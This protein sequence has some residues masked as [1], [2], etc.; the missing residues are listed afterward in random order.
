MARNNK[1][2]LNKR[3]LIGRNSVGLHALDDSAETYLKLA[4][5][6]SVK[7]VSGFPGANILDGSISPTA[8]SNQSDLITS[9]GGL[10]S[11]GVL[12]SAINTRTSNM[13]WE[14]GIDDTAIG[15]PIQTLPVDGTTNPASSIPSPINENFHLEYPLSIGRS[16]YLFGD[17]DVSSTYENYP[18]TSP[19]SAPADFTPVTTSHSNSYKTF[20]PV[21]MG[22]NGFYG[23]TTMPQEPNGWNSTNPGTDAGLFRYIFGG[24]DPAG[25]QQLANVPSYGGQQNPQYSGSITSMHPAMGSPPEKPGDPS[26]PSYPAVSSHMLYA[27]PTAEPSGT[28]A[29]LAAYTTHDAS[30]F[31]TPGARTYNE[32]VFIQGIKEP[33]TTP[34]PTLYTTIPGSA[35]GFRVNLK[36]QSVTTRETLDILGG[37]HGDIGD[38]VQEFRVWE[39]VPVPLASQSLPDV[40][41]TII[42]VAKID[43]MSE[44]DINTTVGGVFDGWAYMNNLHA[45]AIQGTDDES[46]VGRPNDFLRVG[47]TAQE[48]V[49]PDPT[50]PAPQEDNSR[51]ER[52]IGGV[53][54]D[55]TE[56]SYTDVLNQMIIH[57]GFEVGMP[58]EHKI[59]MPT[60]PSDYRYEAPLN[61]WRHNNALRFDF[62]TKSDNPGYTPVVS[63]SSRLSPRVHFRYMYHS[64]EAGGV[65]G[66]IAGG[67]GAGGGDMLTEGRNHGPG[68]RQTFNFANNVSRIIGEWN[69][70]AGATT[71]IGRVESDVASATIAQNIGMKG[72]SSP[73]V[74]YFHGYTTGSLAEPT[75]PRPADNH[76]FERTG[77]AV[78]RE[79]W[80]RYTEKFPFQAVA[81][82]VIAGN[83]L[84]YWRRGGMSSYST[85][86][87]YLSGGYIRTPDS[88]T[89]PSN[90]SGPV[91]N[92]RQRG[93]RQKM[94]H[95]TETWSAVPGNMTNYGHFGNAISGTDQVS[96]NFPGTQH[97]LDFGD[98]GRVANSPGTRERFPFATETLIND[99]LVSQKVLARASL[100][101]PTKGFLFEG[102]NNQAYP[103]TTSPAGPNGPESNSGRRVVEKFPFAT[104]TAVNWDPGGLDHR[105]GHVGIS[106]TQG[107]GYLMTG[108]TPVNT[109][110]Y[111]THL[112]GLPD[113]AGGTGG[114]QINLIASDGSNIYRHDMGLSAATT[115]FADK[116][117]V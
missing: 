71:N 52:L 97:D 43:S 99:G 90:E 67:T 92:D 93:E 14:K 84:F 75:V 114:S 50:A 73:T 20:S 103:D 4:D 55:I 116:A 41:G 47:W 1:T 79:K 88:G 105:W 32:F 16:T 28:D 80:G 23:F 3:T 74:A 72:S 9:A 36:G 102:F 8:I 17:Q 117:Q 69:N 13:N 111:I 95:S 15:L 68:L 57:K 112:P 30:P 25:P 11:I 107:R 85:D 70:P 31:K 46:M 76:P 39:E 81:D 44:S 60:T 115:M 26:T 106:S 100:V 110:D 96:Y 104:G 49:Q 12:N 35:G 61:S 34:A 48:G 37:G 113:L 10:T 58:R 98:P 38:A 91:Y 5:S 2:F 24:T 51:R 83:E 87:S 18:R 33:G 66:V 109:T 53:D 21:I 19:A 86:V 101:S 64:P 78:P 42:N 63:S 82:V 27:V 77:S 62:R 54:V 6:D 94:P 108:R 7:T 56:T 29:P 22:H 65:F 59:A 45:D 40:D 89:V